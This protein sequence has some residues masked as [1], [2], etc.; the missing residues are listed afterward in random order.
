MKKTGSLIM[1]ISTILMLL[2][3][4]VVIGALFLARPQLAAPTNGTTPDAGSDQIPVNKK[5]DEKTLQTGPVSEEAWQAAPPCANAPLGVQAWRESLTAGGLAQRAAQGL[6]AGTVE[7]AYQAL[8]LNVATGR[9]NRSTEIALPEYPGVKTVGDLLA[10][11]EAQEMGAQGF[12][13]LPDAAIEKVL[14]GEAITVPVCARLV[15]V[16]AGRGPSP[17]VWTK[18]GVQS[19]AGQALAAQGDLL[20][21]A[22]PT[23]ASLD[24]GLA[25]PNGQWAAYTSLSMDAGGPIFIQNLQN[26]AWTNL[27]DAMNAARAPEQ[28]ELNLSDWWTVMKWF[29]DSRRL[30]IGRSDASSVIVVDLEGYRWQMIPFAGEGNGGSFVTDLAPDGSEF[31][32]IGYDEGGAQVVSTYRFADGQVRELFKMPL[33]SGVL[34]FPRYAPDGSRIAYLVQQGD[35]QVGVSYSIQAF[36]LADATVQVLAPGNVGLTVPAWSPDGRYVAYTRGTSAETEVARADVPPAVESVNVW[37]A[38]VAS[39]QQ[40]QVTA[41]QGQARSPVW[42]NDGTTLAFV[43]QTGAVGMASLYQPGRMWLAA[44]ASPEFPLLTGVFFT[45]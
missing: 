20:A 13:P 43:T 10:L 1:L 42:A 7:S 45:P 8:L 18:G 2:L 27:I 44:Q 35:P 32:F 37:V 12:V 9:L 39:G 5:A 15:V 36:S 40:I 34:Y 21:A 24:F 16:Q 22:N 29:P 30:F 33:E 3:V 31:V 41:V 14:T 26:G 4:V 23:Q 11:A 17:V 28:P 38:Q 25:S 6:A 19:Q